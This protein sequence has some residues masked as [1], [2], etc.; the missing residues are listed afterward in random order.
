MDA[1]LH[2]I[3]FA[4]G[5]F[6]TTLVLAMVIIF[7][8]TSQDRRLYNYNRAKYIMAFT[9]LLFTL[10][11]LFLING[12]L[13]KLD[14][15]A[16]RALFLILS[17]FQLFLFKHIS[18]TLLNYKFFS[19]KL[20]IYQ[21]IPVLLL[22]LLII[23]SHLLNWSEKTNQIFFYTLLFFHLI[24][25]FAFSYF[26]S[27]HYRKYK[28]R[29]NNYFTGIGT[30]RLR[31]ILF[32]FLLLLAFAIIVIIATF[33][34]PRIVIPFFIWG[35]LFYTGYAIHFLNYKTIFNVLNPVLKEE[36]TENPT[37]SSAITFS[38]IED[39]LEKWEQQKLFTNQGIT[40]ATLATQINTNRSYLSQYINRSKQKSFNEWINGLRIE[41][42]KK[43]MTAHKNMTI[44]EVSEKVGYTDKSYFSKC[45]IKHTGTSIKQ[46]KNNQL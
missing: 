35:I 29:V 36:E 7:S 10:F 28:K 16:L 42:A 2:I 46:W 26:F 8:S 15:L 27:I 13:Q 33:I 23:L 37:T 9:Y 11:S 12:E 6:W 31:W 41:E 17:I 24:A 20:L 18:L 40:I 30:D 43:V 25:I 1:D 44:E 19:I 39:A 3:V 38:R 14:L 4:A 45:F 21:L 5:G 22:S 34:T 32:S